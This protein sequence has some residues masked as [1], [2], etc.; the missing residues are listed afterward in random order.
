MRDTLILGHEA[1]RAA[2]APAAVTEAVTTALIAIAD[3]TVSAP[4]RIAAF[5]PAGLLGAMPAYV[6]GLGLSA[7]LVS[8]FDDPEHPGRSAHQGVVA[9]F[10]E[11]NG[12]LLALLDGESVTAVRT[13]ACATVAM[14]ALARPGPRRITVIGTGV[15]ATAQLALLAALG[16]TAEVTVA[17]R[18]E[19]RARAAA[20]AF[21]GARTA[22]VREAVDGADV[23]FCCT[24]TRTPVLAYDWLAPGAHV[25]S[26]GGFDGCELDAGTVRAGSVFVEWPGAVTSPPPA[27]AD[28]L[29]GLPEGGATLIG[30]VLAGRHPGRR[31]DGETTVFKSTGHAALD[32]AAAAVV[33]R[34]HA[35]S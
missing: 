14:R 32:T 13:A 4:P 15:Q 19:G 35:P 22:T 30:D 31:T 9:L 16:T 34:T 12:S 27:G 10:D 1:T 28:E 11:H 33:Y 29:Q 18:D 26:V 7:K 2:L 5:A 8:V 20:Q 23:V 17:G 3:G 24:A 6:P 21:P 25:S